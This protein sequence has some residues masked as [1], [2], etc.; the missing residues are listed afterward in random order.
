MELKNRIAAIVF[1]VV[2]CLGVE[3]SYAQKM[4]KQG[5]MIVLDCGP[6]SGFP[7]GAVEM[8]KG[9]KIA[10]GTPSDNGGP[11][12]NNKENQSI[13]ATVYHKLEVA[14]EDTPTMTWAN[15]YLYCKQ[16]GEG[17]RLPTQRELQLIYI[18]KGAVGDLGGTALPSNYYWAGTESSY[19][20][21]WILAPSSGYTY[22][23]SKTYA[24]VCA[25]CV[26]E[27]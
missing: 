18:F 13:N 21:N 6:G 24:N 19:A 20:D 12:A 9:K 14:K 23:N 8:Q 4:Y 16:Q 7:Q 17:W 27:L 25:R 26:R 22:H 5:E 3:N 15:A 11:M 1:C 2:C 10:V